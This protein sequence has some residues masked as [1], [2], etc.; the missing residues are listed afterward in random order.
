MSRLARRAAASLGVVALAFVMLVAARAWSAPAAPVRFAPLV[1]MATIR[2][3][4]AT[5]VAAKPAVRRTRG[6]FERARVGEPV[7]IELTAYCLKGV[8]RRGRYV[9]G[10]IV[11]ADPR[12]FPL[13]RF[14]EVFIAGKYYGRFLVD[15]TGG[16]IKGPILDVWKPTCD[17]AVEFGRR[18]GTAVLLPRG[19]G[20]RR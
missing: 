15:D 7:P 12:I 4:G 2:L 19:I 6:R 5:V 11:A 8:T 17:E 16:K 1:V 20:G 13:G 3:P 9:R 14:L 18:R 10:G